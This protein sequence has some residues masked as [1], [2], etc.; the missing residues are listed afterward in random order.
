MFVP[1][2]LMLATFRTVPMNVLPLNMFLPPLT[3]FI[4]TQVVVHAASPI[5][6]E[7]MVFKPD[8]T[9]IPLFTVAPPLL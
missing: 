4:A 2:S 3:I 1:E 6:L 7:V 8:V 5:K 9:Y